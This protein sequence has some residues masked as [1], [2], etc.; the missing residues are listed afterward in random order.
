[1]NYAVWKYESE[2]SPWPLFLGC[3]GE[4]LRDWRKAKRF[5]REDAD[6]KAQEIQGGTYLIRE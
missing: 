3:D 6:A 5:N 4:W 1:M 2:K